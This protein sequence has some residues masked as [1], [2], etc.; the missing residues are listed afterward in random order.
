MKDTNLKKCTGCGKD[1]P[2]TSAFFSSQRGKLS[3]RCRD[4]V[5]EKNNDYYRRRIAQ[6]PVVDAEVLRACS[7][8]HEAKPQTTEFYRAHG[9][10]AG[11]LS[12]VCIAC[13]CERDADRYSRKQKYL[14]QQKR[15]HYL[16]HKAEHLARQKAWRAQ[17]KEY[18]R[19]ANADYYVRNREKLLRDVWAYR[20]ARIETDAEFSIMC[21]LRTRML[22][23]LAGSSKSAPTLKLLGGT[24]DFLLSYFTEHMPVGC[25]IDKRDSYVIDHVVPCAA[26]CL[27]SPDEQRMC[28][29][30]TNL[31]PVTRTYNQRKSDNIG[32]EWG[33]YDAAVALLGKERVDAYIANG[34]RR[35]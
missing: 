11:G 28:F 23:A 1:K 7:K 2:A 29:H 17:N 12:A 25:D 21:R 18:I 6:G 3:A 4:C 22:L 33:N 15:E 19:K 30:Y 26:F 9:A 27:A 5:R 14:L 8:C 13:A 31:L 10:G 34:M 32:P 35:T 20:K 24:R 16:E